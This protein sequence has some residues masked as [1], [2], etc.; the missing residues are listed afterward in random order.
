MQQIPTEAEKN[1]WIDLLRSDS[2][3]GF[4]EEW[5]RVTNLE[6]KIIDDYGFEGIKFLKKDNNSEHYFQLGAFPKSCPWF[7]YNELSLEDF[8]DANFKIIKEAI[9]DLIEAIKERCIL[10]YAE[11]RAHEWVLHYL[12]DAQLYDERAYFRIYTGGPPN[13]RAKVNEHLQMF[14]WTIPLDLE[15]FYAIHDGFG[16]GNDCNYIASSKELRVL[17]ELMNPI[18]KEQNIKPE[19]YAFNDLLEFCPDGG[20]NAQCFYRNGKE[21]VTTVDWDHETWEI[22]E[23]ERFFEFINKRMTEIDEE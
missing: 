23:E 22:S 4:D 19:G 13:D 15:I 12:L 17:G 14:D 1:K 2:T 9:N 10:I 11:Q 5:T 3:K 6:R 8:I 21:D 16:E 18:S 7:K 20:G